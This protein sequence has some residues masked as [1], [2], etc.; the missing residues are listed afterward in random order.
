MPC[1]ISG[2]EVI[3]TR[4]EI[5]P[6]KIHTTKNTETEPASSEESNSFTLRFMPRFVIYSVGIVI[7]TLGITLNTKTLLGVSPII[8]MPYT[9]SVLSGGALG[10]LTFI[11]YV[12]LISLQFVLLRKEFELTRLLQIFMSLVSSIFIQIFDYLLPVP[13]G[14]LLR[15]IVLAAAIILTG[16]GAAITV[17]MKIVPNPADGLADV[18]GR[19][20]GKGFGF[21]KNLFDFIS[22]V[23]SASVGLIFGKSIIGIG[24]GTVFAMI[25]TGR[26]IALLQKP[27]DRFMTKER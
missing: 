2:H 22:L 5:T 6:M 24:I 15:F 1:Q 7:L 18:I 9:I 12:I 17:A 20:L 21:G 8:S 23:F 13:E 19:K 16:I 10:V 26:V 4:K 3:E 11:F 14:I 25:F 27:L